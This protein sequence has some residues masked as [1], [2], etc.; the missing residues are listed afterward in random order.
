MIKLLNLAIWA[1]DAER[2]GGGE[3]EEEKAVR[4]FGRILRFFGDPEQLSAS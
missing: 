4:C 2:K 3:E 1:A